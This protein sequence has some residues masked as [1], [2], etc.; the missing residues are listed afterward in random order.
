MMIYSNHQNEE[1][2]FW[3]FDF[4][5]RFHNQLIAELC[6]LQKKSRDSPYFTK[7]LTLPALNLLKRGISGARRDTK[8]RTLIQWAV[9]S[10]T[11]PPHTLV[12]GKNED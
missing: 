12:C 9:F 5:F 10:S 11:D 6:S 1:I 8:G 7:M 3:G 4:K 2:V